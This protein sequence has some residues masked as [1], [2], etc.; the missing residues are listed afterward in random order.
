MK[1]TYFEQWK[2]MNWNPA[3]HNGK[4]KPTFK[5][6][7]SHLISEEQLIIENMQKELKERSNKKVV[8]VRH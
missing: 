5:E 8:I 6:W 7:L 4:D 1:K 2:A 3:K